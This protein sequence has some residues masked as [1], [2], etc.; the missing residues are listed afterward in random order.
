MS[1]QFAVMIR[2]SGR[3]SLA[4]LRQHSAVM[5]LGDG[6]WTIIRL[7]RQFGCWP[8][9]TLRAMPLQKSESMIELPK[10]ALIGLIRRAETSEAF[11]NLQ[12]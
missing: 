7:L 4:W 12:V 9:E 10:P 6:R 8:P 5:P 3:R 2:Q 11:P 1:K